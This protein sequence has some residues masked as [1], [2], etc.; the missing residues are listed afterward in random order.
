MISWTTIKLLIYDFDGVMTDNTAFVSQDGHEMVRVNRS[1]GLA[2]K[3]LKKV[4]LKQ[5]IISTEENSVVR[6]RANKL[7]IPVLQNCEDK[8]SAVKD[9]CEKEGVRPSEV[10]F[11]GNDINDLEAMQYVG[12]PVSPN[13]GYPSVRNIAKVVTDA[14]GGQGVIRELYEGY[15][16][17]Q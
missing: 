3:A 5:M 16:Q 15:L 2:I 7:G 10:V 13:D 17:A 14:K 6:V 11:V 9:V 12:T 8:L 1:D 4:G